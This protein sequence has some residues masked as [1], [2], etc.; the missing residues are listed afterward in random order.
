MTLCLGF[1][2]VA[3]ETSETRDKVV[4]MLD[5]IANVKTLSYT[6][7]TTELIDDELSVKTASAK[8]CYTQPR[9]YI[10]MHPPQTE[11]EVL[12]KEGVHDNDALINPA[13]FPYFNIWLDPMGSL[14]RGNNHHTIH[15]VGFSRFETIIAHGLEKAGNR[16]D[17]FF[18][19]QPDTM[20]E[21]RE[22]ARIEIDNFDYHFSEYTVQED[23]TVNDV[24]RRLNLSEYKIV[25]INPKVDD[26]DDV[27]EGDVIQIPSDYARKVH[28][29]MDVDL[30]LPLVLRVEDENGLFEQY[31]Y[32]ELQ[33]NPTLT[34]EDFSEDNEAYGF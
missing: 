34:D 7:R 27:R 31:E 25:Q 4:R 11:R 28:I 9:V 22:V 17:D 30:M 13:S 33:L 1:P 21:G 20:W 18:H 23:E 2:A 10:K 6:M 14:M 19:V 24:A 15:D 26:Y 3:Q 29:Y 5:A 12:W 8:V 16:F 32:L